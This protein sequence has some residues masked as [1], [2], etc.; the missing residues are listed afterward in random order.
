MN[1]TEC[2]GKNKNDCERSSEYVESTSAFF[3]VAVEYAGVGPFNVSWT[4]KGH[5]LQC[6]EDN[7]VP[8]HHCCLD[9]LPY[10]QV[11]Y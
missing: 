1:V 11:G 7:C 6:I 10:K 4:L 3:Y 5:E 9:I 2:L 8:E